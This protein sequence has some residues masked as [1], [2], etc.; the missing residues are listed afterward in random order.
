MSSCPRTL[1]VF[2]AFLQQSKNERLTLSYNN[3]RDGEPVFILSKVI[4]HDAKCKQNLP[5]WLST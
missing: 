1:S 3:T 2:D 5:Q 4:D